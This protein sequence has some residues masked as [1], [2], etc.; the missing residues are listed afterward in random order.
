MPNYEYDLVTLRY[1]TS[2]TVAWLHSF[3]IHNVQNCDREPAF[4]YI[5]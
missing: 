1:I 3:A 2:L 4:I 5:I